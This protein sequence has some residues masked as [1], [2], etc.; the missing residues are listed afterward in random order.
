LKAKRI[1]VVVPKSLVFQW[2]AEFKK[3]G[4]M[5][6]VI[7]IYMGRKDV[8][9]KMSYSFGEPEIVI[10]GY[11]TLR[12]DIENF[13]MDSRDDIDWDVI[14]CDEAHRLANIQSATYKALKKLTATHRFALTATP[15]MN[16]VQDFYGIIDWLQPG[17]LGSWM[18]FVDRYVIKDYGGSAVG[19]RNIDELKTKL[20]PVMIRK[21]LDEVQLQLP[22]LTEV[23]L[24]VQLSDKER[25]LYKQIQQELL[26]QLQ[27]ED[28]S[29]LTTPMILQHALVKLGKLQ[30]LVDS[31]ELIGD[32]KDSSKL[33]ALV[34]H[35]KD[36]IHA[37]EK[38]IIFTRFTRMVTILMRELAAYNPVMITGAVT[39]L[40]RDNAV[41]T[42]Q[43]IDSCRLMIASDAGGAGLNLQA[44]SVVYNYDLPWSHGK[45]V[46]RIGRAHRIGQ[47]KPVLVVN[48][49]VQQS[50]D[51]HVWKQLKAKS[52]LS[53]QMLETPVFESLS[54]VQ[55]VLQE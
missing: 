52:R 41:D 27:K 11:D 2:Q 49:I 37:R 51:N 17:F 16:R 36:S 20:L 25:K 13:K 42:F 53:D 18:R 21:T 43:N 47:V 24:P 4:W 31:M 28:I 40:E 48:L 45:L 30:E 50:V 7:K 3:W 33:E 14:I 32:S 6:G 26:F 12:V 15:L 5:D 55:Q 54:D 35:L 10:V 19:T 1:L 44:A 34:E 8:R 29:K 38:A 23:E 46:Q 22:P 9:Q 39:G